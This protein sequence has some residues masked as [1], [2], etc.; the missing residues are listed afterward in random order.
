MS[1]HLKQ[2]HPENKNETYQCPQCSERF[3]LRRRLE[4]HML[5]RHGQQVRFRKTTCAQCGLR[6][7]TDLLC[8]I[9]EYGHGGKELAD[10]LRNQTTCVECVEAFDSFDALV[11]HAEIHGRQTEECPVCKERF[12]ALK[13]HIRRDHPGCQY[14]SKKTCG[15]G[16]YRC[17]ECGKEFQSYIAFT[18][19]ANG[20]RAKATR[21]ART[22]SECGLRFKT[23]IECRLH[24]IH[25][26]INEESTKP[27][28]DT[29]ECPECHQ[30]YENLDELV[31][32]LSEH[33]R[34]TEKCPVCGEWYAALTVHL[35]RDHPD[36][37][38]KYLRLSELDDGN[39]HPDEGYS[40]QTFTCPKC[41]IEFTSK[42]GLTAH[43]SV[44]GSVALVLQH[45][46]SE[47]TPK[48]FHPRTT[49]E[50]LV[51]TNCG[52]RFLTEELLHLHKHI[53]TKDEISFSTRECPECRKLFA[54]ADEL[55]EHVAEHATVARKCLVCGQWRVNMSQHF[56]SQHPG[57]EKE[58]MLPQAHGRQLRFKKTTC[59]QC[60]LRF[61][62]DL[63]CLIHEYEHGRKNLAEDIRRTTT[64]DEC[65]EEFEDFDKLVKHVKLHGRQTKECP[66]CKGRF[67]ALNYHIRAFHPD[68]QYRWKNTRRDGLYRC[69]ECGKEFESF[70]VYAPH[71]TSHRAKAALVARTCSECGLR[72]KTDILSRLHRMQHGNEESAE[73]ICDTRECPECHQKFEHLE[74]LVAH[75]SEH[76]R[77]TQ[78]CPVCGDWYASLAE[79]I[80]RYHPDYHRRRLN[81]TCSECGLRFTNDLLCRLHE[82][83]HGK[84]EIAE[85]IRNT[86]ECPQG[87]G[88]FQELDQLVEHVAGHGKPTEKCPVCGQ[89]YAWLKEHIRRDHKEHYAE[90][91]AQGKLN[92][93]TPKTKEC[94]GYR[95]EKCGKQLPTHT[96]LDSHMGRH[97][98][99]ELMYDSVTCNECGLRFGSALLCQLHK[100]QHDSDGCSDEELK[101]TKSCP[102]CEEEFQEVGL[103][104]AHVAVHGKATR[105][106]PDCSRWF[107][108]LRHHMRREH[109]ESF[110]E[111]VAQLQRTGAKVPAKAVSD[112]SKRKET[113]Q[114]GYCCT[115]CSRRFE[116][117]G[118]FK[119]HMQSHGEEDPSDIVTCDMCGLRFMN[120]HM[121]ELHKVSHGLFSKNLQNTEKCPE[122]GGNF[123]HLQAMAEHVGTH[124]VQAEQCSVCNKWFASLRHH[125]RQCRNH[126][127]HRDRFES[128]DDAATNTSASPKTGDWKKSFECQ[129]CGKEFRLRAGLQSHMKTDHAALKCVV[130]DKVFGSDTDL[131]QHMLSHSNKNQLKCG[132][133]KKTFQSSRI[134]AAHVREH[135]NG[136]L[137]EPVV[138]EAVP[139][140]CVVC[141]KQFADFLLLNQHVKKHN[142]NGGFECAMCNETFPFYHLLSRHV[143]EKQHFRPKIGI[144]CSVCDEELPDENALQ[145]HLFTHH[146]A[147]LTVKCYLCA[148]RFTCNDDLDVHTAAAHTTLDGDDSE[149]EMDEEVGRECY[150]ELMA[151]LSD[152]SNE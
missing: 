36:Y 27:I 82:V 125:A 13:E 99:N 72:F 124:G 76:G 69:E 33:G 52:L 9:H 37:R 122:C 47:E 147:E 39:D 87:D 26:G 51:C 38:R 3:R 129:E 57:Y 34:A 118:S 30:N 65:A 144:P 14:R 121:C 7:S 95:C 19:H 22:C 142:V 80:Q 25:H 45:K 71:V 123:E 151:G 116:N 98:A 67:H 63:L 53:H 23:D 70:T 88:I 31:A 5:Q 104:G 134:F 59:V 132:I 106:C 90:F 139:K 108:D 89:S 77:A 119:R 4:Q 49:P 126:D 12:Q 56:R 16:P 61:S 78:Q 141:R 150:Q 73:L 85:D 75:I 152:D 2:K 20:H 117:F 44:C 74:E 100:L 149:M 113:P 138:E 60:G 146:D 40:H 1:Q 96:N 8:R 79:H 81:L 109:P 145:L 11:K 107:S 130:C 128:S 136:K 137:P 6:F 111:F 68:C 148:E 42:S 86:R 93:D 35:R 135:E 10:D 29:R 21:V 83:S 48:K 64:C 58:R 94:T 28:S 62:T 91:V 115:E 97:R 17:E 41:S 54:V 15:D 133:C 127:D 120:E 103:L 66:V 24:R 84:L 110:K 32:H 112:V 43:I 92:C 46:D 102:E 131:Q 105:K 143:M 114:K 101:N 18:R 50:A 140:E 55:V